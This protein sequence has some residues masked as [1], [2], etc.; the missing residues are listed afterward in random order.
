VGGRERGTRARRAGDANRECAVSTSAPGLLR[1]KTYADARLGGRYFLGIVGDR[2]HTYG[3]HLGPDRIPDLS[4]DY[5]TRLPRDLAGARRYPRFACGYDIGMGWPAS[6][7][8]LAWLVRQCRAGRFPQVREVIGSL[9]GQHKLYWSGLRQFRTERYTGDNHIDHSHLSIYRDTAEQDHSG[10][11][12]LFLDPPARA[13]RPPSGPAAG[14][15][16][17]ARRPAPHPAAPPFPGR[18]LVFTPGRPMM[19]GQDVRTWQARMRQRGWPLAV[20]GVYGPASQAVAVKFQREKSL[21]ADGV[22]GPKT[23]A[24]AWTAP[25]T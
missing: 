6:R 7:R 13:A 8:W 18:A 15:V 23:W 24:A 11:L 21:A 9:D 17:P 5:S 14:L 2:A 1:L 3:Y 16:A 19:T 20:D 25:V 12:R 10:L 22:V 4:A